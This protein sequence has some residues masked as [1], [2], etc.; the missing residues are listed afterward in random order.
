MAKFRD[1][2]VQITQSV[3][4]FRDDD[5]QITQP[6]AGSTSVTDALGKIFVQ[7]QDNDG[8]THTAF[9]ATISD[10]VSGSAVAG[11]TTGSL[12]QQGSTSPVWSNPVFAGAVPSSPPLSNNKTAI[13]RAFRG[14]SFDLSHSVEFMAWNGG[15]G[16]SSGSMIFLLVTDSQ[17]R[18][19][20]PEQ[21][22]PTAL[23]LSL[24]SPVA[25]GAS[26]ACGLLNQ[27]ARLLFAQDLPNA[28][29]WLSSPL[30]LSP[31]AA[32]AYWQLRRS[33]LCTWTLVLQQGEVEL[34][35]YSLTTGAMDCSF[36]IQLQF[37]NAGGECTN[38]PATVTIT[39][40]P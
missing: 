39:P 32:L 15:S 29:F 13:V 2:D 1:D 36:P 33:D 37:V 21:P 22:V 16:G 20:R 24:D 28:A 8:L 9:D 27:P 10:L 7:V 23:L 38:W 30:A 17:Y 34:A 31:G 25:D 11:G 12:T 14:G 3:A 35:V 4:G 5:F 40:A 6:V 26:S 19:C 18:F